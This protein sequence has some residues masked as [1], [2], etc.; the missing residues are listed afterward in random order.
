MIVNYI[1]YNN[2]LTYNKTLNTDYNIK[3]NYYYGNTNLHDISIYLNEVYK[4]FDSSYGDLIKSSMNNTYVNSL[5]IDS[6]QFY[7]KYGKS[8]STYHDVGISMEEEPYMLIIMSTEYS[9]RDEVF[10]YIS[11][12][13]YQLNEIVKRSL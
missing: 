4:L 5:N 8:G 1:G 6:I 7:H 13:I 9:K 12:T 10:Y 2:I 11:N 3:S